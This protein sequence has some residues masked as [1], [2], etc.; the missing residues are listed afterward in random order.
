MNNMEI[1]A[2]VV[3]GLLILGLAAIMATIMFTDMWDDTEV[4]IP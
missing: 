3:G 2:V 1:F 4:D